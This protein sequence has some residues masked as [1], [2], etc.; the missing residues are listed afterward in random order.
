MKSDIRHLARRFVEMG[1]PVVTGVEDDDYA[2]ERLT[3]DEL[4][5]WRSMD[6]R[7]RKHSVD[8]TRRFI[9]DY[10]KANRDEIAAAL[11]HDVGKSAVNLG[12]IG[13]T[14]A[15]IAPLT[16]SMVVYR[17]HERLGGRMLAEIG[18]SRRT[19]DLVSGAARDTAAMALRAA[20]EA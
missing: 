5:L 3:T 19:I 8:V 15:T 11:L 6:I 16:R 7:D 2:A 14:V 9:A 1:Q 13:R 20:D 10:T 17:D 12:R 18:A 4:G